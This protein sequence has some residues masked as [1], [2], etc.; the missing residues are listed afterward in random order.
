MTEPALL[1][2]PVTRIVPKGRVDDDDLASLAGDMNWLLARV[3]EG[4][5]KTPAEFIVSTQDRGTFV[6]WIKDP[7]TG[8]VYLAV[9]GDKREEVAAVVRDNFESFSLAEAVDRAKAATGRADR[10]R[11]I[12]QLALLAP[13]AVDDQIFDIFRSFA[14]DS[15]AELRGAMILAVSYVG[16]PRFTELLTPLAE[17]DPDDSVRQDAA[18]LIEAMKKYPA[19]SRF[20]S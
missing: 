14:T 6:H 9:L 19:R 16:W 18:T 5:A 10:M 4:D 2:T 3:I 13:D 12:Y 20:A 7:K 11:A 15:D 1:T 17:T 8:L